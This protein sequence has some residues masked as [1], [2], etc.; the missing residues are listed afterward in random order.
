[1][2]KFLLIFLSWRLLLF[3]PLIVGYFFVPYR[4]GSEFTNIWYYTAPY[5]PANLP[6]VFP[7]ANFDGVHYLDIAGNGYTNNARFFPLYPILILIAS[8]PFG[9]GVAFGGIQFAIAFLISN[10]CFLA[11][12][13]FLNKLLRLDYSEKIA[14]QS[15]L[16]LLLF[17]TAFFFV[18]VYSEGLFLL[19]TILSFYFARK[20]Q[21]LAASICAALLTATRIVGIAIWPAL[22]YEFLK[23]EKN[24]SRPKT[25]FKGLSLLLVPVGIFAYSWFNFVKWGNPLHFLISQGTLGNSRSV[26]SIVLPPQTLV[27]YSKI[28]LALPS[29]QFEW[30]IALLEIVTFIFVC[31][32]LYVAWKKKVRASYLIFAV[33]AFLIPTLSGTFSALPR[34]AAI[35]FPAYIAL[36]L[37]KNKTLKLAYSVIAPVLL[38]ILL[39]LF[40]RGYF[41]A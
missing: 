17:P 31:I 4:P 1:M 21:W 3:F 32:L 9:G 19:L 29:T 16:F 33:L 34:Y 36:S 41:I 7:W 11:A 5:L 40:A 6:V 14:T 26:T 13:I 8:Q 24:K 15:L 10:A 2:K 25:I 35:L 39:M 22:I 12:L 38:F 30:W 18:S 37:T 23:E 20:K 27:R 28:L